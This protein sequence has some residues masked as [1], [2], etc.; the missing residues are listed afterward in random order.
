MKGS[1][2]GIVGGVRVWKISSGGMWVTNT[3]ETRCGNVCI[4]APAGVTRFKCRPIDQKV[5][6]SLLVRRVPRLWAGSWPGPIGQAASRYFSSSLTP[7]LPLSLKSISKSLGED[8]K[9][10]R[11]TKEICI[12]TW[13]SLHVGPR[14]KH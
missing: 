3:W 7:S 9:K 11:E 1:Q 5:K 12:T 4:T 2:Y 14:R 6:G 8:K 10:L 13:V